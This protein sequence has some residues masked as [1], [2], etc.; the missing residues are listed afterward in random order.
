MAP[1]TRT[2]RQTLLDT[3]SRPRPGATQ[4]I[5]GTVNPSVTEENNKKWIAKRQGLLA[6][7]ED[8]MPGVDEAE[9]TIGGALQCTIL[10]AADGK[11]FLEE[12]ALIDSDEG[13]DL[14]A[15]VSSLIQ[16]SLMDGMSAT[17]RDAVCSVV[18]ILVWLKLEP[19]SETLVRAM[20]KRVDVMMVKTVEKVTESLKGTIDSTVAELWAASTNMATSATQITATTISYRDA[21][22]SSLN[23]PGGASPMGTRLAPRLQAREGV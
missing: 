17:A 19:V 14:D 22:R 21:L 1:T 16:I 5:T 8:G 3:H 20:E 2:T 15:M 9:S 7:S 23:A 4:K 6:G 13:L 12:E 11:V 10:S 18:P